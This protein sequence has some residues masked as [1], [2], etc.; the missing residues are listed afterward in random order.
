MGTD[1][2]SQRLVR[3]VQQR[4]G[5]G[6]GSE[7]YLTLAVALGIVPRRALDGELRLEADR[8]KARKV[9]NW[10][11]GRDQPRFQITIEMLE[12]AGLLQPEAVA[13]L[14]GLS[15]PEA[16]QAVARARDDA[17]GKADQ[18]DPEKAGREEAVRSQ[19]R[20]A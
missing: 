13:A 2:P 20:P 17:I 11:E 7:H 4:L 18:V 16:A 12:L 15:L 1:T 9:R 3:L 8:S 19:R 14:H 6:N 5:A 10:L